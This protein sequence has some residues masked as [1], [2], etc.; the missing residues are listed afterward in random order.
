MNE[1]MTRGIIIQYDKE[2]QLFETEIDS[3]INYYIFSE[4]K[5]QLQKVLNKFINI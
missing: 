1:C 5:N 3:E 2:I 4:K